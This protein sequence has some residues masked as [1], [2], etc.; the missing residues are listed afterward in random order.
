MEVLGKV[1]LND[2]DTGE[3]LAKFEAVFTCGECEDMDEFTH[4]HSEEI[5]EF[6]LDKAG[7]QLPEEYAGVDVIAMLD[8]VE[9]CEEG[10]DTDEDDEEDCE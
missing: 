10:E 6:L 2:E 5:T 3:L 9:L 7:E 1:R 8:L 4:A